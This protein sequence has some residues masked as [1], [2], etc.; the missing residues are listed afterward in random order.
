MTREELAL[1]LNKNYEKSD[2]RLKNDRRKMGLVLKKHRLLLQ[3]TQSDVL[4]AFIEMF[5]TEEKNTVFSLRPFESMRSICYYEYGF[6][7]FI[8]GSLEAFA[9]VYKTS[10]EALIEE[11]KSI[12]FADGE[13]IYSPDFD[14][15]DK[16]NATNLSF[17]NGHLVYPNAQISDNRDKMGLTLKLKRLRLQKTRREISKDT[18]NNKKS[19]NII[20]ITNLENG[21]SPFKEETLKTFSKL[22]DVSIKEL[23]E[24]AQRLKE[25]EAIK[26]I[27]LLQKTLDLRRKSKKKESLSF[28]QK[29]RFELNLTQREVA[30]RANIAVSTLSH[31]ENNRYAIPEKL[32]PSLASILDVSVNDIK[33]NMNTRK[34]GIDKNINNNVLSISIF[35]KKLREKRLALNLSRKKLA[36]LS[37]ISEQTIQRYEKQERKNIPLVNLIDLSKSL[38]TKIESLVK[39]TPIVLEKDTKVDINSKYLDMFKD[40]ENLSDEDRMILNQAYQDIKNN[41][42]VVQLKSIKKTETSFLKKLFS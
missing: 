29:R 41:K 19:L 28:I 30:K 42:D 23:I 36:Q 5:K 24:E 8:E 3:M 1:S 22:F 31:Y 18:E 13:T 26:E 15:F 21:R 9:Q 2:T 32:I 14:E 39:E 10:V 4:N 20:Q 40:L 38:D 17:R 25:K 11:A 37:G 35:S 12:S 34:F 6:S 33:D 7:P 16:M 27:S